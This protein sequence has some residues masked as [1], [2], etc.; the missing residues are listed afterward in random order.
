M[1]RMTDDDTLDSEWIRKVCLSLTASLVSECVLFEMGSGCLVPSCEIL[2]RDLA[3]V[4][5][6]VIDILSAKKDPEHKGHRMF[7]SKA[8]L[9]DMRQTYCITTAL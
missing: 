1:R 8:D 5:G 3:H 4:T 7:F 2:V 6:C 9:S